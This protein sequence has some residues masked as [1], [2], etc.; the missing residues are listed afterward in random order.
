MG[1]ADMLYLSLLSSE[2]RAWL[3]DIFKLFAKH[4]LFLECAIPTAVL[5]MKTR[6]EIEVYNAKLCTDWG[7]LRRA[8]VKLIEKCHYF[9]K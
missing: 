9:L 1:P 5:W 3:L 6:F 2:Q 8:P 4:S 7:G